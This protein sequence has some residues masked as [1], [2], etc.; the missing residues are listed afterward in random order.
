MRKI[1]HTIKYD[2]DG[3]GYKQGI[4]VT[5]QE[6][7]VL[8]DCLQSASERFVK[9]KLI[10]VMLEEKIHAIKNIAFPNRQQILIF[11]KFLK[12]K[13]KFAYQNTYIRV[14]N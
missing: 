9:G 10:R 11:N 7:A 12:A 5:P 14:E 6:W 2:R 1:S 4:I 3:L 13:L 8:Q